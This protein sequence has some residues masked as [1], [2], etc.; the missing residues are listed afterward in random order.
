MKTDKAESRP[1]TRV[2]LPWRIVLTDVTTRCHSRYAPIRGTC[3]CVKTLPGFGTCVVTV[4]F[5][6]IIAVVARDVTS[7]HAQLNVANMAT[8]Q[9]NATGN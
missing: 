4:P 9:L 2:L 8:E 7:T 3:H 1:Q 5:S 6:L